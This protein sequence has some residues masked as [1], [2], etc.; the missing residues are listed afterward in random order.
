MLCISVCTPSI[1]RSVGKVESNIN[2]Y[3]IAFE[4]AEVNQLKMC[5]IEETLVDVS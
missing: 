3:I 5:D 4:S 2:K 1:G